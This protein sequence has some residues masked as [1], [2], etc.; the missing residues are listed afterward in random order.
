MS[1]APQPAY[2]RK[3][4]HDESLYRLIAHE[5]PHGAVFVVDRQLRYVLAD[6]AEL[7]MAGYAP[8]DFEGKT[9]REVVPASLAEQHERDYRT[10]LGGGTFSREHEVNQRS[11]RSY[12][13]PL[14]NS[15]GEAE[16]ALVVSYDISD[17]VRDERQLSLLRE[18]DAITLAAVDI[19]SMLSDITS[20]LERQLGPVTCFMAE[21]AWQSSELIEISKL[22]AKHEISST[23]AFA[24][25]HVDCIGNLCL[26]RNVIVPPMQTPSPGCTLLHDLGMHSLMLVPRMHDKTMVGMF[27]I[28]RAAMHGWQPEDRI[29]VEAAAGRA[30]QAVGR[31]HTIDRLQES[32]RHKDRVL[33]LLGHELRNPISA[34][35]TGIAL[36]K[37][38]NVDES[39]RHAVAM[40]ERQVHQIHHTVDDLLSLSYAVFGKLELRLESVALQDLVDTV[41]D[42]M[43]PAALDKHQQLRHASSGAP[44]QVTADRTKLVQVLTN[45]VSNAVKYTPDGGEI[46]VSV[47]HED[48]NSVLRVQDNGIGMDS[49]VIAH[50]FEPSLPLLRC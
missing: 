47:R 41:I 29:L 36:L 19:D 10:V 13:R 22:L 1:N 12:G 37:R 3:N 33:A 30:W 39:A 8:A 16:L 6:G 50:L 46:I 17:Q 45:L 5:L 24:W 49:D 11:Y 32:D 44:L 23:E 42:T 18:L 4:F 34:L 31:R 25:L 35:V 20:L 21:V 40:L 48:N 27:G 43:R 26:G 28:G 38:S 15:Q 14:K 7:A 9:V 2:E